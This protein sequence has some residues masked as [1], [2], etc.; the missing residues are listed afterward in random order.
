MK[1]QVYITRDKERIIE[2][3]SKEKSFLAVKVYSETVFM[4]LF[5]YK[6]SNE[7]LLYI[8]KK[9]HVLLEVAKMYLENICRFSVENQSD[10]K[11][12]FLNKIKGE[13]IEE[14]LLVKNTL[15]ERYL[16]EAEIFLDDSYMSADLDS[17][18]QN[19]SIQY[20]YPK[21]EKYL[22]TVYCLE[23]E[24]E[25][26]VFVLE[27]V[28]DLIH[29]GIDINHII[30]TNVPESYYTLLK[31][32]SYQ[33]NIP[34][35]ISDTP[36]LSKTTIG[37]KFIANMH[38]G[39]QE[40]LNILEPLI[41]TSDDEEI[42]NQI[43]QIVNKYLYSHEA[44]V[45]VLDALKHSKVKMNA[46][47]DTIKVV[48]YQNYSF[49]ED[50]YVFFLSFNSDTIPVSYKDEEYLSDRVR[51]I[52]GLATS[53]MRNKKEKE[54]VLQLITSILHCTITYKK[55]TLNKESYPSSLLEDFS[56]QTGHINY[57]VSD[58]YN[59]YTLAKMYDSYTKFGTVTDDFVELSSLYEIPYHTYSNLYK[60]IPDIKILNYLKNKLILSYSKM[61]SYLACPFSFY[62]KYI[63][64]IS[65]YEETFPIRIGNIFHKILERMEEDEFDY[66]YIFSVLTR[67]EDFSAREKFLLEHL[68]EEFRYTLN[69]L[70]DRRKYTELHDGEFERVESINIPA[71]IPVTFEGKIDLIR[72]NKDRTVFSLT[73]YKTGVPY[74]DS[75]IMPLGF[76]LQLPTYLYLLKHDE[77][78]KNM[79][80]G[81]FYL[82][83]IFIEKQK[84]D[85]KTDYE[86]IKNKAF[87][88]VGYSNNNQDVLG[89]CDYTYPDSVQIKSLKTKNDGSFYHYSKVFDSSDLETLYNLVEQLIEKSLKGI[90]EGDFTIEPKIVDNKTNLSCTYCPFQDICFHTPKDNVY[91]N[92][93]ENFLKKEVEHGLDA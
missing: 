27:K 42:S 57:N 73:D 55:H 9:Y 15:M 70:Q 37:T 11:C 53:K 34:V 36:S 69:L 2:S 68:K 78:F 8:M 3:L 17:I 87:K 60:P 40:A 41:T 51:G 71:I 49:M 39:L 1:R 66:D 76:S 58:M 63:L 26:I 50:D 25:E 35:N 32:I 74:L 20:V 10:E 44:E 18:L 13:L 86:V 46:S 59:Q 62:L 52:M 5:P 84:E 64:K 23:N 88:A 16:N 72:Y 30:L 92:S 28:A 24:E 67:E 7:A 80:C 75:S 65:P 77:E 83:P 61:N 19:F 43:M 81:G 29:Q 89:I 47:Y 4:H 48:P 38:L 33:M 90:L 82:Q 85:M 79:Q 56:I 14:G 54:F 45:F 6:Y 91:V 22:P 31:R 93:D 21:K 12:L